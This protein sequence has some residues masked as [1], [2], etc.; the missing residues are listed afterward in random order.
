[1]LVTQDLIRP[2][3]KVQKKVLLID[4][5]RFILHSLGEMLSMKGY[6]VIKAQSAEEG[7][8]LFE[9]ESPPIITTDIMMP[10]MDGLELMQKIHR[11]NPDAEVIMITAYD[12]G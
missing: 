2:I 10:D 11:I 4:D 7:L 3:A 5:D 1:M 9:K 6:Q 12:Q 8:Q